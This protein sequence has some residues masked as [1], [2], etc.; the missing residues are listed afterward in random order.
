VDWI[1]SQTDCCDVIPV[2]SHNDA[3]H[4]PILT[5]VIAFD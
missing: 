1:P 4:I 3:D 5:H 2:L